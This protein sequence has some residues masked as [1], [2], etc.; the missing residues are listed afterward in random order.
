MTNWTKKHE[1]IWVALGN[2][3][4]NTLIGI[5]QTYEAISIIGTDWSKTTGCSHYLR[6]YV[7]QQEVKQP[8]LPDVVELDGR[9][10]RAE[11]A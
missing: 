9:M 4:H 11:D 2:D 10:Y 8:V 5:A 1:V 7:E 3:D 6:E